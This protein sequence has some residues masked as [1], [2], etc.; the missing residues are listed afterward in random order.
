[1]F[2]TREES[3]ASL[4]EN[5][6]EYGDSYVRDVTVE[7]LKEVLLS[8]VPSIS[9]RLRRKQIIDQMP[10]KFE[11]NFEAQ[12]FRDELEHHGEGLGDLPG[13]I[14]ERSVLYVDEYTVEGTKG[15]LWYNEGDIPDERLRVKQAV[16]TARFAGAKVVHD[17]EDETITHIVVGAD[18]DRVK[19]LRK[20]TSR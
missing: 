10:E 17:V 18:R 7:E 19:T 9:L 2:F 5:I 16:D 12:S 20:Q 3:K 8:I 14:F 1:M 4:E 13:W 11:Y 15:N 6:D